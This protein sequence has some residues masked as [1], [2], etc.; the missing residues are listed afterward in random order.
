MFWQEVKLELDTLRQNNL[1]RQLQEIKPLSPT[2]AL[3]DGKEVVLFCTNNYLGLTHHP[4]VIKAAKEAVDEY[5]AGSGAARLISGHNSLYVQ[6]ETSLARFKQTEVALVFPTGYTTNIGVISALVG[7]KDAIFCDKLAHASIID[8]CLL[9]GAKFFRYRHNDLDHLERQLKNASSYRRRLIVTEGVFS[10][11]GDLAP[12]PALSALAE[13]YDAILLVDDAHGTGVMGEKGR[14]TVFYYGL[15]SERIIQIATLSKA[16]SALGGFVAGS[17]LLIDYLVNK[18]RPF[19]FTTALPPAVVA[20][21]QKAVEVMENEPIHWQ[22]LRENIAFLREGLRALGLKLPPYLT[23]IIPLIVG[24]PKTAL[25]LSQRLLKE[26]FFIPA[27]RP[28]TVPR[29]KARLRI[30]VSAAHTKEEME[31]LLDKLARFTEK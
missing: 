13:K 4:E 21:A 7:R 15:K 5:G 6:L 9:S 11:D 26:G 31:M 14:G 18:A 20:T 23:P 12:L 16:I 1:W 25:N 27:I 10:M 2:R 24:E 17:R 8:G 29:G 30:T 28:P 22:R 19:I 3:I